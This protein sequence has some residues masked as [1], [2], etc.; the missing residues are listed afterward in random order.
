MTVFTTGYGA[1]FWSLET[2]RAFV[3][4][5]Y[6]GYTKRDPDDAGYAFVNAEMVLA[7]IS[8]PEYRARFG[9]P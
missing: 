9:Q 4:L 8:S 1:A 6:F 5:Q 2:K 3:L 7:F